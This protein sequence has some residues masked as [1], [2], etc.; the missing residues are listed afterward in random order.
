MCELKVDF[1][2]SVRDALQLYSQPLA[3]ID[4]IAFKLGCIPEY[5]H[6]FLGSMFLYPLSLK[7]FGIG[8]QCFFVLF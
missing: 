5:L 1:K 3:K 2:T 8:M 6:N 7:L 4:E